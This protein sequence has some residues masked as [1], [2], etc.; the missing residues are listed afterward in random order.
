MPSSRVSVLSFRW[1]GKG[2][3]DKEPPWNCC[4]CWERGCCERCLLLIVDHHILVLHASGIG[5]LR[6]AGL[7]HSVL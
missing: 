5:T 3:P 4:R 2:E 1:N 7:D 6:I